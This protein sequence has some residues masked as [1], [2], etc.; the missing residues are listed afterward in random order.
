MRAGLA[1]LALL[2]LAGTV[3]CAGASE[4]GAAADPS[5]AASAAQVAGPPG[6]APSV[7]AIGPAGYG[8]PLSAKTFPDRAPDDAADGHPRLWIREADLPR[9]RS[10]ARPQNPVWANGVLPRLE[11]ARAKWD[12]GGFEKKTD[13]ASTEPYCESFAELFAFGA[14]VDPDP[15]ARKADAARGRKL[16]VSTLERIDKKAKDDP[17]SD[18]TLSVY[19]RSRWAGEAFALSVD[20]LHPHLTP[21]ERALARRV[22]LRWAE[23]QLHATTTEN[24]H[25]EPKGVVADP[26]L[27]ADVRVRR[28]S[29]NNYY[30]AH[31]RNLTLMALA[32]DPADDPEEKDAKRSSPSLRGYLQ[33]AIGAWWYV[34]DDVMRKDAR[35]GISPEG[36]QYGFQTLAYYAQIAL[37]LRTAGKTDAA[38]FPRGSPPVDLGDN[39]FWSDVLPATLHLV[40]PGRVKEES[41]ALVH[42]AASWG[43]DQRFALGDGVD[44]WATWGLEAALRG[45][46]KRLEAARWV[47]RNLPSPDE[48]AYMRRVRGD[49]YPRPSILHFLITDPDARPARDPRAAM[50]LTHRGDGL[51]WVLARTGWD[52]KATFFGAHAG[53]IQM[54]HQHGDG[55]D[56]F[57][58]RK[59]EFLT[60][61]RAG[62]GTHFEMTDLHNAMALENVKPSRGG[63]RREMVHTRGSQWVLSPAGDPTPL[64]VHTAA[65]VVHAAWDLTPVYNST[66]EEVLDVEHASRSLTWLAPDA[67]VVVDRA[68]TRVDGRFRRVFFQL[69]AVAEVKG[70]VATTRTAKGQI[71]RLEAL[72]PE[73]ASLSSAAVTDGGDAE[74]RSPDT[75]TMKA[76]LKIE[77]ASMAG[78][79][80]TF[81]HVLT[82]AD[83]GG[84]PVEARRVAVDGKELIGVE[85]GGV[86]VLAPVDA[87]TLDPASFSWTTAAP[88]TLV[89]GLK[90]GARYT[91]SCAAAGSG[92]K[93]SAKREP[94]GTSTVN[95]AGLL[96]VPSR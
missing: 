16:L 30:A 33:N 72:L 59:G 54:D 74:K 40:T 79:T 81:V 75:E 45:D 13:C 19:N 6:A 5:A 88:R 63:D 58:Y 12:A 48:A 84:K 38:L 62:W 68:R 26:R 25:P 20:W 85:V 23:E 4:E 9:L 50:P 24:N 52:E 93:C 3:A 14:L 60:K 41:G 27:L 28:Y 77:P 35:G 49:D 29:L 46:G 94:G 47:I 42:Q 1:A 66:Y 10:W 90:G 78:K 76:F 2:T 91:V 80:T 89:T 8:A 7:A 34:A 57:L 11:D 43:D 69:P 31:A 39:P 18:P 17:L 51:G 15:A 92:R 55:G 65:D 70:A 37:A 83:A 53:W 21:P 96:D 82:A 36:A 73:R 56:F 32:L 22:F 95:E 86:A 87:P 71:L 61:E 67:L 64:G 44:L